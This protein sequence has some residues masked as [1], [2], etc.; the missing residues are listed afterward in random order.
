MCASYCCV[1]IIKHLYTDVCE[2]TYMY[3]YIALG[4][5]VVI[6]QVA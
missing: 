6:L 2:Y 3:I 5:C 1:K 4:V